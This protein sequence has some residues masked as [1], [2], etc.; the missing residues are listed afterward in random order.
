MTTSWTD[1]TITANST[2]VR[3]VH[4]Q[5]LRDAVNAERGRR[6][7]G[8]YT[9]TD[10]LTADSTLGRKTHIDQLRQAIEQAAGATC[11]TDTVPVPVWTDPT[12]QA[13][14]TMI[15]KIHVTEMRTV[16]NNME[17]ACICDCDFCSHCSHSPC[18]TCDCDHYH[19]W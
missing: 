5:E 14:I 15:R 9:F 2:K 17:N 4:F 3:R 7:L 6:G 19:Q 1:P 12:I 10:T 16:T 11:P 13:D 8:A 18:C